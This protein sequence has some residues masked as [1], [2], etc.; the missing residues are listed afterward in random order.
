[1]AKDQGADLKA[2]FEGREAKVQTQAG[3][4]P[5]RIRQHVPTPVLRP[6]GS[7]KARADAVDQTVRETQEAAKAKN[8]WAAR[9]KTGPRR[10]KGKGMKR[11][12]S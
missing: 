6:D 4:V 12:R 9:M 5:E 2:E 8:E 10:T 3:E 11:S 7:W 1:M